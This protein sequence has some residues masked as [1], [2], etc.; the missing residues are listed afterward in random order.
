MGFK[1]IFNIKNSKINWIRIKS[2]YC[3]FISLASIIL[4]FE[5]KQEDK[6]LI[7]TGSSS[8]S[9]RL[10]FEGIEH[11]FLHPPQE[12]LRLKAVPQNKHLFKKAKASKLI[13]VV[14]FF[15]IFAN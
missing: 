4:N 5:S 14:C 8:T 9:N 2:P 6:S 3:C 12:P 7:I 10:S 11:L 1:I 15:F 13:F